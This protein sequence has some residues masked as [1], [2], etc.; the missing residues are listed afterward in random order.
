MRL[1][2][3][4]VALVALTGTCHAAAGDPGWIYAEGRQLLN[5]GKPQYMHGVNTPWHNWNEFGSTNPYY[6]YESEWWEQEF[7][8]LKAMGINSVRVWITCDSNNEGVRVRTDGI[9]QPPTDQFWADCDD[10]M[11]LATKYEMYVMPTIMSFDHFKW[12][13]EGQP[14]WYQ[15]LGTHAGVQSLIDQY[16]VP[17]VERYA[18]NPYCWAID[19]CNEPEWITQL[20]DQ[21]TPRGGTVTPVGGGSDLYDFNFRVPDHVV[22]QY[23][24]LKNTSINTRVVERISD[25]RVRV[26]DPFG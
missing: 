5:A 17:F 22:G 2:I 12:G 4:T 14:G 9:V 20:A 7:L 26:Q 21:A 6:N 11:A 8:R 25:T 10:L 13:H 24:Y 19:L 3:I 15:M 16:I 18:D 23:I 1:S